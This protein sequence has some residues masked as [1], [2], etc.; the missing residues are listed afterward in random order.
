MIIIRFARYRPE[1]M[2]LT[3]VRFFFVS[4]TVLLAMQT[5]TAQALRFQ[6]CAKPLPLQLRPFTQRPQRIDALCGN[7]GCFKS[8]ANDQQNAAKNNFCAPTN[9]IIPVTLETFSELNQAS[10]REPTITKGEPPPSRAKLKNIITL[11]NG[12]KLGEG[13]VVSFIGYTI[14]AHHSN[15]DKDN[16]LTEGNGESVQ[17]NLLGCAYND[18]HITLADTPN[19]EKMCRTIVAEII[20]HFRPPAWDLFD[21]PDF[22]SFLKTHP[23]KITGQLFF[24]GSHVPCTDEGRAGNNPARDN[25]RD[26]ER[27]ALWEIH[28]IYAIDVC[29][30]TDKAQCRASDTR[31]WFPFSQLKSVLRLRTVTPLARCLAVTGDPNHKCPNFTLPP[32]R[33]RPV[34]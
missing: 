32:K 18:I 34:R 8:A 16:P 30:H 23:V 7:T 12:R 15:V 2:K 20:P 31:A 29:R 17:C 19:Q 26:F 22:D 21:S 10:N 27:L 1:L 13:K 4:I 25:R 9:R 11:S 5:G 14:D 24:D 3:S 33:R 28:P 6:T